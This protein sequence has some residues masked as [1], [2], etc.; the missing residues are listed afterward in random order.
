MTLIISWIGVDDKKPGK[1]ISSLYIAS[2]SRYSAGAKTKFDY[3]IKVFGTSKYPEIFGFCGDVL[4][5]STILGQIIPQI[6]NGILLKESDDCNTKNTKIF[7]YIKTSLEEYPDSFLG[8]TFTIIHGT[9]FEKQFKL[10]KF[11][12]S[13]KQGIVI[14]DV[15]LGKVST[16]VLS[17]G[18][19]AKEFDDKWSNIW[20]NHKH[21][22]YRTSRAVY[23]CLNKTLEEIKDPHTGGLPQIVGLYRNKNSRIFGIAENNNKYIYG[24]LSSE[25]INSKSIEWRN[26]NFE[27]IDP[28]TLKILEGAQKQPLQGATP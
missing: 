8:S 27:R 1:E 18:S 22:D 2:D 26:E 11:F 19:G 23:H 20:D 25:D 5:P 16:K 14:S 6:D 12:Y 17:D 3:G 13:K 10:F 7:N 15:P 28:E 24:K 21:N 9:R 4:F